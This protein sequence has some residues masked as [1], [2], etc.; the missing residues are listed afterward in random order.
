GLHDAASRI[1]ENTASAVSAGLARDYG[2]E[3]DLQVTADGE[4]MVH[5]DAVLGRVTE[6]EGRLAE[7]T[8]VQLKR[9]RFHA[10]ADRMMSLGELCDVV[11]GRVVLLLELKSAFDGDPRLARRTAQILDNYP[12]PVAVM[13]FDPTV[14]GALKDI[15][16]KLIRGITAM[17]HY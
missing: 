5:H 7:M 13:S 16:P 11:A 14:V 15:A 3:V 6:G 1:I 8:A 10:T 17:G 12:G 2:I 4:A 9:V